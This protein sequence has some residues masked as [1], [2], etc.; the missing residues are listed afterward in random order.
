MNPISLLANN[1][2]PNIGSQALALQQFFNQQRQEQ[3]RQEQFQK[4]Q[5][6]IQEQL[7]QLQGGREKTA[8]K[9]YLPYLLSPIASAVSGALGSYGSLINFIPDIVRNRKKAALIEKLKSQGFN[10]SDPFFQ[11]QMKDFDENKNPFLKALDVIPR[12]GDVKAGIDKL[13]GGATATPEGMEGVDRIFEIAGSF[14]APLPGLGTIKA[15]VKALKNIPQIPAKAWRAAKRAPAKLREA[16]KIA[17]PKAGESEQ[18]LS[19][20]KKLAKGVLLGATQ[21]TGEKIFENAESAGVRIGAPLALSTLTMAFMPKKIAKKAASDVYELAKNNMSSEKFG[22]LSKGVESMTGKLGALD[23]EMPKIGDKI[24]RNAQTTPVAGMLD[25]L[26]AQAKKAKEI[27]KFRKILPQENKKIESQR[28]EIFKENKGATLKRD[29]QK[30]KAF[31]EE[32]KTLSKKIEASKSVDAKDLLR[33]KQIENE[34]RRLKPSIEKFKKMEAKIKPLDDQFEKNKKLLS[35]GKYS[36]KELEKTRYSQR[37]LFNLTKGIKDKEKNLYDGTITDVSKSD[38]DAAKNYL[39]RVK[40][41]VEEEFFSSLEKSPEIKFNGKPTSLKT[42]VEQANAAYYALHHVPKFMEFTKEKL[43]EIGKY[44]GVYIIGNIK[45]MLSYS[46]IGIA[47]G[48]LYGIS[49]A[50]QNLRQIATDPIIGRAFLGFL[51]ATWKNHT[52]AAAHHLATINRELD[53]RDEKSGR[54]EPM[55]KVPDKIMKQYVK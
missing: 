11:E 14:V 37:D 31:E 15:P 25:D 20:G 30:F 36:L 19:F 26:F 21:V 3:E 29:N 33:K 28:A 10:E 22:E 2:Q 8:S 18:I 32:Y 44:G 41:V 43:Q 16:V 47:G 54:F 49:A 42:V 38:K 13:T 27:K 45:K 55:G 9:N 17:P 46:T 39:K 1:N 35:T 12:I 52:A 7:E 34:L 4:Q 5:E 53:K 23:R 6:L 40:K 51:K 24:L 50:I 48:G